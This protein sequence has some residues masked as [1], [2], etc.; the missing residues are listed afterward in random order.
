MIRL[1]LVDDHP[2]VRSGYRRLL[3]LDHRMC[4]VAEASHALQALELLRQH[5]IDVV[6]SDVSMPQA[7]IW[8]LFEGLKSLS[9]RPKVLVC[10]MHDD[11]I[12]VTR[13]L[14]AG[15][16]GFLTKNSPPDELIDAVHCVFS[17]RRYISQDVR[18]L[19]AQQ[20]D[21]LERVNSLTA[22]ER[23]VWRMLSQGLSAAECAQAMN[24]S[25]K[26]VA[27][28]QTLIKEKLQV[29]TTSALVHL[30]QRHH[31]LDEASSLGV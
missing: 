24:L 8:Q 12:L 13:C 16:W 10:S 28:Y 21:E 2:V 6:I 26:T 18:Q 22:R 5:E 3:E 7:D 4:V 1:M 17:G 29:N 23:E 11:A 31:L 25:Q 9:A 27:N 20:R 30:A 19:Q 15:A 14:A